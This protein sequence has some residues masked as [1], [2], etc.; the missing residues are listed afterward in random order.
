[1]KIVKALIS[2]LAISVLLSANAMAA[3][4]IV[5]DDEEDAG[6]TSWFVS[7]KA[8]SEELSA[9]DA[10]SQCR[11]EGKKSCLVAVRFEQCAALADSS[12]FYRVGR[13]GTAY[14]ASQDA[15]RN[16]PGCRIVQT[17]CDT[18]RVALNR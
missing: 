9:R 7:V 13:G 10:L 4:A 2:T 5:V 11:N 3:G 15:L 17:A 1:M 8:G 16:C 14:E 12:K 18:S 6:Q